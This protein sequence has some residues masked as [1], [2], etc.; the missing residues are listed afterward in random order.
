VRDDS[1][2]IVDA[3]YNLAVCLMKLNSHAEAMQLVRQAEA[4]L[5]LAEH[6]KLA[7]L[8]LLKAMLYHKSAELDD[9]WQTATQILSMTPQPATVIRGRTH[10]LRGLIASEREDINQLQ[11]EIDALGNPI[12]PLLRGD[13]AELKGYLALAEQDWVA[14]V[15]AFDEAV[16]LRRE[17]IDYQA[18]RKDLAL[19]AEASERAGEIKGASQ[20]YLRAGRSAVLQGDYDAATLWLMRAEHLAGE[21]D[22]NQIRHE[23]RL[24]LDQIQKTNTSIQ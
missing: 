23:A 22:E 2:A 13:L 8:L 10:F 15:K 14:A 5:A 9:A 24:Y 21:A 16:I 17:T 20:R 4:E 18:M 11:N 3:Q 7:D 6:S 19:A 12:N 1:G